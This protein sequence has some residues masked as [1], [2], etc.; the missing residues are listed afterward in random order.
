M[1]EKNLIQCVKGKIG[2]YQQK[3]YIALQEADIKEI[4]AL[5][6]KHI[7]KVLNSHS[8]KSAQQIEEYSHKDVPWVAADER[9]I[10]PYESVFYRN[11]PYSVEDLEDDL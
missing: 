3:K 10:I 11:E 6:I 8:D 2:P 9:E 4:S 7:D 1:I 5:E